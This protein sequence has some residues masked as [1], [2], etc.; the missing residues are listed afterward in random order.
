MVD[1]GLQ[2]RGREGEHGWLKVFGAEGGGE[3]IGKKGGGLWG[4]RR[5]RLGRDGVGRGGGQDLRFKLLQLAHEAEIGRDDVPALLDDVEGRLQPQPLRPHDVGHA[6]CRGARD[7]R[8]AV[9][10]D[11]PP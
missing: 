4:A 3:I 7:P 6:D 5:G 8:L 2:A 11:L 10:Q 1:R 9:D